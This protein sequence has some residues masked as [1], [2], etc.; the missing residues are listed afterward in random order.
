MHLRVVD[1]GVDALA[2]PAREHL[3]ALRAGAGDPHAQQALCALT[4]HRGEPQLVIAAGQRERDD[5][6]SHQLAQVAGHEIEQAVEIGFGRKGVSDLV[7]GL[8]LARPASRRLVEA[9]VLDRNGRLACEE[10]KEILV[11]LGEVLLAFLLGE[12]EVAVGDPAEQD[13]D[14]EE[15]AHRGMCGRKADRAQVVGEV[16][17]PQRLRLLDQHSE[18]SAS[19][20]QRADRLAHVAVD[21]V[22]HELLELGA[23]RVD[24]AERGIASAGQLGRR[25]DEPLQ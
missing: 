9:G 6:R 22:R 25:L 13:R 19:P 20:R 3:A 12:V 5:P 11:L 15:G 14:A 24:H 18:N 17:Q 2:S 4:G 10:R 16:V 21:P 1:H 8:E 23:A 7:Q